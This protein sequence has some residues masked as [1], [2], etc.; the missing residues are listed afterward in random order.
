MKNL[1]LEYVNKANYEPKTFDELVEV[2]NIAENELDEF[3]TII[4]SLLSDYEIFLNKKKDRVISSRQANLFKGVIRIKSN[5]QYGFVESTLPFDVYIPK[6]ALSNAFNGDEVLFSLS[7][8][9]DE[10]EVKKVIKRKTIYLVG[11]VYKY[12]NLLCL[13]H[14][15]KG[16]PEIVRL[17]NT[18]K[19]KS[20]QIIRAK[21]T[22]YDKF[23]SEANI[24]DVIGD[25][26]D[27]GMDITKIAATYNFTNVFPEAVIEEV[28]NLNYN[29]KTETRVDYTNEVIF[30]IDG[31]DAKDLDDAVSIKK[32]DNGNYEL[33]VYIADVSYYVREGSFLDQEAYNRG[34]SVYLLDRVIPMLPY[35]LSN[36]LCSLNPDEDKLVISCIMEIDNLG[37]VIDSSLNE[38][39]IKT[40]K[41]L[42]YRDCNL[43]LENGVSL[44]PDYQE[45][46]PYLVLMKELAE[47]LYEKKH[48]R[49]A[50][51]FDIPEIK[52][53]LDDLGKAVAVEKIERGIS[54]HII[55][56]F[57]IV[58]NETVAEF[59]ENMELPFIY[60][61][62][63]EPDGLKFQ[64][65]KMIVR[66][67][68]YKIKSLH[69]LELQKLLE[70]IEDEGSYLKT[71]ILRLMAK[72]VYS[73][74]NIGHFGLASKS[75]T[76]FTSPI[77][78]YPDL[79]VHRLIRKY[80]FN[81]EIDARE[82]LDLTQK[83][84][85]IANHSSKK[86]REAFECEMKVLDMKKTEY[87][88]NFIGEKFKGTISSVT[89]FGVFVTVLDGID[90][91]VHVSNMEG[92]Y[93]E[94]DS[95]NN[96]YVGRR[97][98]KKIKIGDAVD[99][100]LISAL[101]E[102]SEIDFK[103]VYNSDREKHSYYKQ[104]RKNQNGKNKES[105]VK[106]RSGKKNKNNRK[107]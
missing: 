81:H 57:M 92:D 32:L 67:L 7:G 63:D 36:D 26:S 79:L 47:K 100:I 35:K 42:N 24:V 1:I 48:K 95:Y 23:I 90:G 94:Y 73:E 44:K 22:K 99:V 19:I 58:A 98:N 53:N 102:N 69:P 61:V 9:S 51:D 88:E 34:T 11:T 54:E 78:R 18:D 30:T 103:L 85:D 70:Y 13:K 75:Y 4:Q 41:R 60:R 25:N 96:Q 28:N 33:G 101:K 76:H 83:I 56:E 55:E 20:E 106:G 12:N 91:L 82:F 46:Y 97:S 71:M 45:V 49:G 80:I 3:H 29:I 17:K 21:I 65:L 14:S 50:L 5:F 62:H 84:S 74:N 31:E 59:I 77:R 66:N 89:R 52:V 105:S 72:A 6:H 27:I 87:M 38:G 93:F 37:N 68:G 64:N 86:E 40:V 15:E 104:K 2:L 8:N 107:K 43:V 39:V 16:F 10:G